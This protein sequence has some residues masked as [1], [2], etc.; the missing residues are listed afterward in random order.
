MRSKVALSGVSRSFEA[1][2][3]TLSSGFDV[4][5]LGAEPY[6]CV[7]CLGAAQQRSHQIFV[8][9][10]HELRHQLD[11][12]D[13]CPQRVIDGGHLQANDAAT[14]DQQTLRHIGQLER[15]G[16]VDQALV[17]VRQTRQLGWP[18]A[19]GDHGLVE[20]HFAALPVRTLHADRVW[21]REL[22]K[23]VDDLDLASF[24][25][26]LESTHEPCDHTLLEATQCFQVD[27]RR[28]KTHAVI[29]ERGAIVDDL[30]HVK[31]C[32]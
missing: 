14:D 30:T 12:A 7:G 4:G 6:C 21:R 1:R 3:E 17:V 8:G 2:H 10:R 16:R 31:Q 22:S 18:G 15:S 32:L 24:G 25:E 11:D 20:G 23:T 13:R 27:L 26:L 9:S 28:A 19:H 5:D 29:G